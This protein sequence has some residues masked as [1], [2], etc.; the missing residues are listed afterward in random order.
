MW[1][2]IDAPQAPA[3]QSRATSAQHARN[4]TKRPGPPATPPDGDDDGWSNDEENAI[5]TDPLQPC[6]PGAWPPDITDYQVVDCPG[7]N[8]VVPFLFLSA[9][10]N[11]RH[12]LPVDGAIGFQDLI[13]ALPF[14]FQSRTL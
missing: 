12:N 6:G 10:G 14:P 3:G 4:L 5:G 9:T 1:T 8:A 13:A 11:E 7:P 2:F